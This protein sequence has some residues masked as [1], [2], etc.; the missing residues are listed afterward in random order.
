MGGG[1]ILLLTFEG[2]RRRDF[3]LAFKEG[4]AGGF[5]V[6]LVFFRLVM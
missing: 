2:I 1:N 4:R 6:P 3:S 5:G